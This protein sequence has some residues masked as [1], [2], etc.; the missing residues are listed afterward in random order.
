MRR[1]DLI[2][3]DTARAPLPTRRGQRKPRPCPCGCG[4]LSGLCAAHRERLAA[5]SIGGGRFAERSD[6]RGYRPP[7]CRIPDCD[8]PRPRGETFCW[9]HRDEDVPE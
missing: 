3:F 5:I 9:E 4:T 7:S 2:G 8:N 6:Q 1:T